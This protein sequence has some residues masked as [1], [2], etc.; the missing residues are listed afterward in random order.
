M[1]P[2]SQIVNKFSIRCPQSMFNW[3]DDK[4]TSFLSGLHIFAA[5]QLFANNWF[6]CNPVWA[7][8]H[9]IYALLKRLQIFGNIKVAEFWSFIPIDSRSG[10][11]GM[12]A[13]AFHYHFL[14]FILF[15]PS[16]LL[17]SCRNWKATAMDAALLMFWKK[18]P[19]RRTW[20]YIS[21]NILQ[22]HDSISTNRC[23]LNF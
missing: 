9:D 8:C 21:W 19:P 14:V 13:R 7:E 22:H 1:R 16:R 6:V 4:N 17:P 15:C 2:L 3:P 12:S 23:Y 20:V 18:Q 11:L 5:D 10:S